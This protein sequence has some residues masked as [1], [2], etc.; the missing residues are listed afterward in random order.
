M[1]KFLKN[2]LLFASAA[3]FLFTACDSVEDAI[4]TAPS[5]TVTVE[6]PQDEY[7]PGD[8]IDLVVEFTANAPVVGATINAETE[9]FTINLTENGISNNI[10]DLNAFNVAGNTEGS[11]T[12]P[13]FEIPEEAA[14][15]TLSFTV[16]MEDEEGRFGEGTLDL[17]IEEAGINFYEQVLFGAQGN[18]EKGF[19]N[20]LD[21]IRYSYG[22]ARD[23]SGVNGS[24]VD[25]AYYWGSNNKNTIASIDDGGLNTVY[26]S[27]NLPIE[28]IFG[29]RNSTR[30]RVT[31]LSPS[32]FAE[33]TSES[34][35]IAAADSELNTNSSATDLQ[36]GSV[37]AFELDADRGGYFGLI[38]VTEINDT[39]GTGTVTI[40]VKVQQPDNE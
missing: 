12:I 19:Y 26:S 38:H 22:E 10:I 30:F 7:V 4:T 9:D 6:D 16:E 37:V 3:L 23:A 24:P 1:K 11:F 14:N 40:E 8:V 27:V 31:A 32:E 20:S 17:L 15:L 33:I 28:N 13:G 25:F 39:N 18:A 34:T 35:L 36:I 29:P 21:N 2:G 5:V